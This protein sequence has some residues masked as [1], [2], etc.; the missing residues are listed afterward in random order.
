MAPS[1]PRGPRKKSSPGDAAS[2]ENRF[3]R[4]RDDHHTEITED[5]V[6]L[7]A[8]LIEKQGE[9]RV[10]DMARVLGISSGTATKTVQKLAKEGFLD[11][12]PYR[13]VF[14]TEKGRKLADKCHERHQVVLEFL[15]SIG[16]PE[17]AAQQDAE[18]IE[19]HVSDATLK[20]MRKHLKKRK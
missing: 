6:E 17:K 15:Q 1:T 16:V 19:H 2:V 5:Y 12:A 8:E 9:A 7:V 18:G 13:S 10:V 3:N 11:S 14:L 4:T 20:A